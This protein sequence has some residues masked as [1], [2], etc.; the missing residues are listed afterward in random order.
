VFK[1]DFRLDGIEVLNEVKLI[2]CAFTDTRTNEF[3]VTFTR[4]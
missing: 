2:E 3:T 4:Q 1:L